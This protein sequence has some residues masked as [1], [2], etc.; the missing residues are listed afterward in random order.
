[1]LTVL[2]IIRRDKVRVINHLGLRNVYNNKPLYTVILYW[3][4]QI[5]QTVPC[6]LINVK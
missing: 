5:F 6:K 4:F 1:M 2:M 3:K